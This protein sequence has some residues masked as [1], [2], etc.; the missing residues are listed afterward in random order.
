MRCDDKF[1]LQ[2]TP[3][4]NF[5][6]KHCKKR[7]FFEYEFLSLW[8]TGNSEEHTGLSRALSTLAELEEKIEHIQQEQVGVLVCNWLLYLKHNKNLYPF[9]LRTSCAPLTGV[10]STPNVSSK[11]STVGTYVFSKMGIVGTLL[12]FSNFDVDD[13]KK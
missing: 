4:L 2:Y 8:T 1:Y 7:D 6:M 13:R 3:C 5:S 12:P 11:M 9:M 10:R